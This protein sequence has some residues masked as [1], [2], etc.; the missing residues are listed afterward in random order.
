MRRKVIS[1]FIMLLVCSSLAAGGCTKMESKSV[2][3]TSKYPNQ[4]ITIIVPFSAG[5]GTILQRDYLRNL[6][7]NIWDKLW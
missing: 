5:S 1:V 6:H 4:P 2:A 7:L 3:A